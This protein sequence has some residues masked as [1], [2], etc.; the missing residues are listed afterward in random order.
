MQYDS[1]KIEY[2]RVLSQQTQQQTVESYR[3]LNRIAQKG[4]I[5]FTGSSLMEQFPITE[6]TMTHNLGKVVYN[7]G[8][9]GFT[10]D[11]FLDNIG[12]LLLDLAPKYVF[13]NIGTNDICQ[14]K[15][16]TPWEKHLEKGYAEILSQLRHNC[17]DTEAYLMAYYPMNESNEEGKHFAKLMGSLRTNANLKKANSIV[18]SLAQKFG[19]HYIDVN[20]GLTDENGNLKSTF[21]KDSIHFYPDGYEVVFKNLENILINLK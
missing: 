9:G 20:N 21:C 14:Q 3:R 10:V 19:Y 6:L 12:P 5:L 18:A 13:I 8:V 4:Q 17:P 7:R 1:K 16:K 11:S 2:I 15:D